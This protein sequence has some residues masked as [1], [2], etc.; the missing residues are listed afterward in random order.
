MSI[1]QKLKHLIREQNVKQI[2]LADA[3]GLSPSRLSNYLA[4][5]RE[6]DLEMLAGMAKYLGVDLN[7]FSP[8]NFLSKSHLVEPVTDNINKGSS[9]P[10]FRIGDKKR[11]AHKKSLLL[12]N[13]LVAGLKDPVII[14][15]NRNVAGIFTAN[16]Y[17]L[18]SPLDKSEDSGALVIETGRNFSIYRYLKCGSDYFL[19]NISSKKC[20]SPQPDATYF[21]VRVIMQRERLP[22][23]L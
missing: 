10:F 5:K 8:V 11:A 21:A 16:A 3:M 9:V 1:G 18:A 15:I 22:Q 23:Y 6:P 20:V 12:D 17:V 2:R 14:E 4:D 13:R 19:Y 7:Y